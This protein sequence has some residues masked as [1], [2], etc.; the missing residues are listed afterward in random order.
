MLKVKQIKTEVS[1][2]LLNLFFS[3]PSHFSKWHH[4]PDSFMHPYLK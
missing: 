1:I 4:Q 2:P 3:Q